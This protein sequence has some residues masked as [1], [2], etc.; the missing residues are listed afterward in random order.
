MKSRKDCKNKPSPVLVHLSIQFPGED[1]SYQLSGTMD[2]SE[3]GWLNRKSS[4]SLQ[5]DFNAVIERVD[6]IH[7]WERENFPNWTPRISHVLFKLL[8][9]GKADSK[10]YTMKEIIHATGFSERAIRKQ[11][12]KFEM[13]GWLIRGKNNH[14]RRNS[15]IE[16][17]DSLR[18]AYLEWLSLH[19][20]QA[21]R[22][23]EFN[24][25]N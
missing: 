23:S 3:V 1:K 16:P 7:E 17:S 19:M 14:D 4:P 15:H 25:E 21:S 12:E 24:E 2:A 13:H 20:A 11:L 8:G 18:D 10:A 5:P 22:A 6:R 9:E